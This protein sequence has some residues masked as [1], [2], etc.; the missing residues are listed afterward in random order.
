MSTS[1]IDGTDEDSGVRNISRTVG[2][3]LTSLFSKVLMDN[4]VTIGSFDRLLGNFF[5][6]HRNNPKVAAYIKQHDQG[7]WRRAFLR[8]PEMSWQTFCRGFEVLNRPKFEI[9]VRVPHPDGS[10]TETSLMVDLNVPD[11]PEDELRLLD[12][13]EKK[14]GRAGKKRNAAV[15]GVADSSSSGNAGGADQCEPGGES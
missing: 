13:L 15:K 2:G 4:N 14:H 3:L 10:V 11:V 1:D 12:R 7:N 8:N 6:R 5:D 9:I